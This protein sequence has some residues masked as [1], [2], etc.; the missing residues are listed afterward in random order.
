MEAAALL[1]L[2]SLCLGV[3]EVQFQEVLV[4]EVVGAGVQGLSFHS[5]GE[6]VVG[7]EEFF[8]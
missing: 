2:R 6:V 8:Y 4:L 7:P 3:V 1:R 5:S